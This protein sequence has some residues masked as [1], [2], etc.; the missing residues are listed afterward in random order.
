M[1]CHDIPRHETSYR[2]T[3][4]S[5][6]SD[7]KARCLMDTRGLLGTIDLPGMEA[8][9]PRA[10]AWLRDRL[11]VDHP[12]LDDVLLLASELVTNA[13]R[14]SDSRHVGTVTV[15][16][17]TRPGVVH[18]VV[19]DDGAATVPR[20]GDVD[21]SGGDGEEQSEGGRGLF[22]VEMLARA[23]GIHDDGAGRAVWFEV[24]Y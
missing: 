6:A 9:V 1:S 23:W 10:R 5:G 24:K 22:L 20:V 19:I 17:A 13:V 16:A 2:E 18:V 4:R 14:H 7:H 11:G 15:A 3:P 12:A 21:V 8:S